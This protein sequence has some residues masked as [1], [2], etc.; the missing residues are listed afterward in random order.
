MDR[1]SETILEYAKKVYD[2]YV[3]LRRELDAPEIAADPITYRELAEETYSLERIASA[4]AQWLEHAELIK[5]CVASG[6]NRET[7][8][9]LQ[10]EA[11]NLIR[12]MAFSPSEKGSVTLSAKCEYGAESFLKTY[13]S[14][15]LNAASSLGAHAEVIRSE[16]DKNKLKY[17][18]IKI[19]GN[20]SG[21][22]A[23][24]SGIHAFTDGN[25]VRQIKVAAC[26]YT[27]PVSRFD[28]KDVRI[29]LTHSDGA[30]GQNVNKVETAVRVR[31]LPTDIT[32]MCRDE[33]SQLQNKRRAMEKL[34]EKVEDFYRALADAANAEARSS[35]MNINARVRIYDEKQDLMRDVP[36]DVFV[37]GRLSDAS[38]FERLLTATAAANR[39]K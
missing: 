4:Y 25:A 6:E 23:S 37:K 9:R 11:E 31:H 20:N 19:S 16:Y 2:R 18:K 17:T 13:S 39:N 5:A 1:A 24:E 22:F 28:E 15:V 27:E 21:Y 14:A 35:A 36:A 3:G 32:V 29:V 30:G 38:A 34:K 12:S 7:V 26:R 33:R 8:E 10:A